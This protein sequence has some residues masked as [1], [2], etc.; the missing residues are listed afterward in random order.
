MVTALK[1]ALGVLSANKLQNDPRYKW[2][3]L[4]LL[5]FVFNPE[6]SGNT[7]NLDALYNYLFNNGPRPVS[8]LCIDDP[9]ISCLLPNWVAPIC[10]DHH[11]HVSDKSNFCH[12]NIAWYSNHVS[13]TYQRICKRIQEELPNTFPNAANLL[14][15]FLTRDAKGL[16]QDQNENLNW[17][18]LR[19]ILKKLLVMSMF[20][21]EQSSKNICK[22][23]NNGGKTWQFNKY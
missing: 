5:S 7:N 19:K 3:L 12:T 20:T 23:N 10:S 17:S 1:I 8:L 16:L 9:T 13:D 4:F 22:D 2:G 11:V 21:E 15:N 18:D 14:L 6:C